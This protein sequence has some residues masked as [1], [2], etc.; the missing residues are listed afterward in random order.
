MARPKTPKFEYTRRRDEG[1]GVYISFILYG[2]DKEDFLAYKAE[3]II[4]S[5]S[6]AAERLTLAQLRQWRAQK[7]QSVAA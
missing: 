5:N 3:E 2:Q 6:N 4:R 1:D 7:E